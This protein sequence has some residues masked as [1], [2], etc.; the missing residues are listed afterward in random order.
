[1]AATVR[2][3]IR[4]SP[5]IKREAER[6]AALLGIESLTEFITQAV[7]EK[8]QKVIQTQQGLI[9][10]HTV[11]DPFF[12]TCQADIKPSLALQALAEKVDKQGFK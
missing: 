1:M 10:S 4:V 7:R 3:E 5:E 6:A 2:I 11:F 8:S 9:L 12:T